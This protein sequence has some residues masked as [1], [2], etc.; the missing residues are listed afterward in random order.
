MNDQEI[1]PGMRIMCSLN[2]VDA[3]YRCFEVSDE[4][5]GPTYGLV[6]IVHLFKDFEQSDLATLLYVMS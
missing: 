5:A 3:A 2:G 1:A 6:R 4:R